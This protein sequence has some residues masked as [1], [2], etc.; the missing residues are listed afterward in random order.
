MI[1]YEEMQYFKK[2]CSVYTKS[3]AL[4]NLMKE[5]I[6]EAEKKFRVVLILL[7]TEFYDDA[8]KIMGHYLMELQSRRS[9]D[10]FHIL[11]MNEG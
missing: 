10:G 1:P 7:Q 11:E 4:S 2:F 6:D 9:V 3:L 8:H 5:D